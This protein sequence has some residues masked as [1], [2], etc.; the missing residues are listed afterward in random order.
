MRLSVLSHVGLRD[1]TSKLTRKCRRIQLVASTKTPR[2]NMARA[3]TMAAVVVVNL[4]GVYV[5]DDDM[6]DGLTKL[7]RRR[8]SNGHGAIKMAASWAMPKDAAT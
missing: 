2:L 3:V 8:K 1:V 5:D 6:D 7:F 4:E